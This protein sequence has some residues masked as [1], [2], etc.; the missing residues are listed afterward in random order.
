MPPSVV[1]RQ[2]SD[3]VVIVVQ[4]SSSDKPA[5]AEGSAEIADLVVETLADIQ[6]P[7]PDLCGSIRKT[8]DDMEASAVRSVLKAHR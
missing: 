8:Y 3:L 6:R 5:V 1:V 2:F 7:E 4:P